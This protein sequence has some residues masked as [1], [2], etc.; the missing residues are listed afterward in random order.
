MRVVDKD[1]R[2]NG[3]MLQQKEYSSV[4]HFVTVQ[5][6]SAKDGVA[7]ALKSV[8][9]ARNQPLPA[10]MLGLLTKLDRN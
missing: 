5:M 4:S 6:P 2:D 10:D 8:F 7:R 1:M 3:K 9:D